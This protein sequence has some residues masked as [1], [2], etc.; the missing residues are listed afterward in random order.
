MRGTGL[1]LTSLVWGGRSSSEGA[2][3]LLL[4]P[5]QWK[6][7]VSAGSQ[8]SEPQPRAF[9]SVFWSYCS[10]HAWQDLGFCITAAAAVSMSAWAS[11]PGEY[12]GLWSKQV[13][14][15]KI[16]GGL[17]TCSSAFSGLHASPLVPGLGCAI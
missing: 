2:A 3:S 1:G 7:Y 14:A 4:R 9:Q 8:E 12:P 5:C 15:P 6:S 11:L 16:Q 17:R 10:Q 13:A